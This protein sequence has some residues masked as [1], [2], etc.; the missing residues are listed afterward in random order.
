MSPPNVEAPWARLPGRVAPPPPCVSLNRIAMVARKSQWIASVVVVR[1]S[2]PT[3]S[4]PHFSPSK[5]PCNSAR[6]LNYQR[7]PDTG[8][9]T[10]ACAISQRQACWTV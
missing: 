8:S 10:S 4:P 5:A 3:Q 1:T 2:L 9:E 6:E 7:W